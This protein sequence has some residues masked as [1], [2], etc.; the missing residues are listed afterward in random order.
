MKNPGGPGDNSVIAAPN[1]VSVG[2][3]RGHDVSRRM[4][5][6]VVDPVDPGAAK[7]YMRA[8]VESCVGTPI[9][10]S[11]VVPLVAGCLAIAFAVS[12]APGADGTAERRPR[13]SLVRYNHVLP[14][15]A[16]GRSHVVPAPPDSA[17]AA[18]C[19]HG[20]PHGTV[21]SPRAPRSASPAPPPT[22]PPTA[23]PIEPRPPPS[24]PPPSRRRYA[25]AEL[26]RRVFAVDVLECPDCHG[27]TRILAAIH[28]PDNTHDILECLGLPVRP[29]PIAPPAVESPEREDDFEL[30]ASVEVL[31]EYRRGAERLHRDFSSIDIKAILDLVTR[32]TRIVELAPVPKSAC[33][34]QSDLKF[35][36]CALAGG[37]TSSSRATVR[38][39]GP[40]DS[41]ES[42]S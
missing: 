21:D 12:S 42:K 20:A 37:A 7:G 34:D 41:G 15:A 22:A 9:R 25:W 40:P 26:M 16:V 18:R 33:G 24:A 10:S 4:T 32:E 38:S 3:I 28:P 29:S 31:A 27:R 14:P 2:S 8:L 13:L 23:R 5:H 11:G 30:V 17:T 36:A 35:L 39:C 19:S 6:A 1:F